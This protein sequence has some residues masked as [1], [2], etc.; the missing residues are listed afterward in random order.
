VCYPEALDAQ[1]GYV[2]PAVASAL[3]T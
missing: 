3:G 2:T 1:S